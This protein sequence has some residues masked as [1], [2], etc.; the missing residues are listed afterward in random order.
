[1]GL[2]SYRELRVWQMSMRLAEDCYRLTRT[3]PK[4]ELFGLTS[5]IRRAS[6]RIPANIAEGYGRG[7][8]GEYLQFLRIAQGS[9]NELEF[10]E[11]RIYANV[12]RQ[13]MVLEIDPVTGQVTGEIDLSELAVQ[14]TVNPEAVLN[15]IAYNPNNRTL[16]V[17]GKLW[18][19][20][21]EIKLHAD[22]AAIVSGAGPRVETE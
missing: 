17:T 18:P 14:H 1:M 13:D 4:E 2:G 22:D 16:L 7:H 12:W 10:I 6:S 3:F 9:L 20:L 5:Q 19:V 11:G 8:R 15:C 21:Y